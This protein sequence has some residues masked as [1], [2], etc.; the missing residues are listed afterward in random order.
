[1]TSLSATIPSPAPS[2]APAP[3]LCLTTASQIAHARLANHMYSATIYDDLVAACSDFTQCYK[4]LVKQDQQNISPI[5][6]SSMSSLGQTLLVILHRISLETVLSSSL[7]YELAC[8]GAHAFIK[9]LLKLPPPPPSFDDSERTTRPGDHSFTYLYVEDIYD[10]IQQYCSAIASTCHSQSITFP[11]PRAPLPTTTLLSRQP[12]PFPV[13]I[14]GI[15]HTFLISQIHARQSSQ[16]DVG[17]VMW[18]AALL[19]SLYV[20]A[21]VPLFAHNT[22]L[23]LG[24]G[25][26]LT[27][28]VCGKVGA[29]S[30]T[31]TDYNEAVLANLKSNVKINEL[32]A[33]VGVQKVDFYES[34]GEAGASRRDQQSEASSAAEKE[35]W[36]K[37][38]PRS[39]FGKANCIECGRR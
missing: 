28:L 6:M 5:T 21:N 30:V 3:S 22:V 16:E 1:M 19:L 35:D 20:A 36:C 7:N 2:H 12:K 25:C 34:T 38:A 15:S 8:D 32:E 31:T 39:G 23:E 37:W 13:P 27:G 9:N 17:F 4:D 29:T 33:V 26:G 11:S 24:A 14:D 10:D 18:P